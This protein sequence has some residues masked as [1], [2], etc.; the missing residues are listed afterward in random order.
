MSSERLV[1]F[2]KSNPEALSRFASIIHLTATVDHGVNLRQRRNPRQKYENSESWPTAANYSFWFFFGSQKNGW[3]SHPWRNSSCLPSGF[4]FRSIDAGFSF[5]N[6]SKVVSPHDSIRY[7]PKN[8]KTRSAQS[9]LCTFRGVPDGL[10]EPS[11]SCSLP[12]N[13]PFLT[14]NSQCSP[15]DFVRGSTTAGGT[16]F[17][18][19]GLKLKRFLVSRQC[20]GRIQCNEL[21]RNERV[22][23]I[24]KS[25]FIHAA[26]N[27]ALDL[28]AGYFV[29]DLNRG[30]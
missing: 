27:T 15:I 6:F 20:S 1:N 22:T 23:I 14:I 8:G 16:G 10:P 28:V 12:G 3:T 25:L 4:L 17:K 2:V 29:C 19:L 13:F 11:L 21:L 9:R 18:S 26:R 24:G 5:A 7:F 30:F